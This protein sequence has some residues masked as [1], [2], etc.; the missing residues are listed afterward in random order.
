MRPVTASAGSALRSWTRHT[1]PT[2]AT[3]STSRLAAVSAT[4]ASHPSSQR[5]LQSA[6]AGSSSFESPF[7]N[8]KPS[9]YNTTKIPSFKSYASKGT[10]V[11]NRVFSYVLVGSMGL[12]TAAGAKATVQGT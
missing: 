9:T 10:E 3:T 11:S 2:S 6:D 5:R 7:Q 1:L 12:L 8:S 4:T